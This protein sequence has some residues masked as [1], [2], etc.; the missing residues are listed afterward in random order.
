MV[1]EMI[2]KI[3]KLTIK[4]IVLV[5]LGIIIKDNYYVIINELKYL[6]KKFLQPDVRQTLIDNEYRKSRHKP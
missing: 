2:E 1:I 6:Y 4:V 3:I 5:I